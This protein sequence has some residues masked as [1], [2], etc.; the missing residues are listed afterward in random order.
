MLSK[1]IYFVFFC[2]KT[3]ENNKAEIA[4]IFCVRFKC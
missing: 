2:K 3:F 1:Y 4:V